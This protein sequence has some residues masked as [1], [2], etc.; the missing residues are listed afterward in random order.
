MR[1]ARRVFPNSPNHKLG[2]LLEYRSIK[3]SDNLHRALADV[4]ATYNLWI[5]MSEVLYKK[6]YID[7]TSFFEMKNYC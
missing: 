5:D 4:K 1:M 7:S 3:Q 6:K 2:T